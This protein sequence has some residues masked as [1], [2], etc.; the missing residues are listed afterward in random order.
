MKNL[1]MKLLRAIFRKMGYN[2]A[3][4]PVYHPVADQEVLE[5]H[6]RLKRVLREDAGFTQQQVS[7]LMKYNTPMRVCFYQQVL[8]KAIEL[9]VDFHERAV[10]D[11]GSHH[12]LML[13]LLERHDATTKLFGIDA[14]KSRL[15]MSQHVCTTAD[16][17]YGTL[18]EP[19]YEQAFDIV[20]MTQVMEHL[21]NPSQA[22]D[23]LAQM[24]GGQGT[25]I[26]TVPDGRINDMPAGEFYP[27]LNSYYGHINFWSLE[28]W[29]YF[30][31]QHFPDADVRSTKVTDVHLLGI[32]NL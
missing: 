15:P 6:D 9:G 32:V 30:L 26:L 7:N 3:F 13:R 11:V 24:T 16:I 29:G 14:D 31:N 27:E 5:E 19:G 18:D 2:V 21:V 20:F 12:G 25:L 8:R 28:S 1:S 4:S 22:L 10:L 17:R 23:Q